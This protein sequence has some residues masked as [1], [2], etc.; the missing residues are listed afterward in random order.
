MDAGWR[1]GGGWH[2]LAGG[3]DDPAAALRQRAV[4]PLAN[5]LWPLM[6]AWHILGGREE[7][8]AGPEEQP[9]PSL[10]SAAPLC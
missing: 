8:L 4:A 6:P 5:A 10:D 2:R 7:P 3:V 1:T 9:M